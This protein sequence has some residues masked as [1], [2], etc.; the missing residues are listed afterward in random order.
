[1]IAGGKNPTITI[2]EMKGFYVVVAP[3][4]KSREVV[5]EQSEVSRS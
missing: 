4:N 1:M 2:T 3:R 5:I